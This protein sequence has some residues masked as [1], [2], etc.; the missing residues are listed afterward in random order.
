MRY[1][2]LALLFLPS[3]VLAI[4]FYDYKNDAN[5]SKG[6][7]LGSSMCAKAAH[8]HYQKQINE[9]VEV[10]ENRLRVKHEYL[11]SELLV[12]QRLWLLY[13]KSA[14]K[15]EVPYFQGTLYAATAIRCEVKMQESRI[16]YLEKVIENAR[17]Y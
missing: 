8:K 10:L 17:Q 5:C 14:C 16:K 9:L 12:S 11:V 15:V 2:V 4:N 13:V 3:D 7:G 1:L 6:S